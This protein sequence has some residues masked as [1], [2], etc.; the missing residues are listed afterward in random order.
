M[1]NHFII[2]MWNIVLK[3]FYSLLIMVCLLMQACTHN[4]ESEKQNFKKPNLSKAASYNAQLGL[5]YL[6][7]GD[8]PRAK[9]KLLTALEQEPASPDVNSA[10][11]YYFEQTKEL[12][13]AEKYY[14]KAISLTGSG[15]AQLNNYGAFLCRQGDY[16]KAEKYFLKAANDVQYIHTAGAYENAG[17]CAL[18]APNDEKA[19]FYFT[20]ALNQ[21]PSRKVSLYEL[22][23]LEIK[24]GK[25][26][27]AF[28]LVQNHPDLVLND[29]ML[30][31]LAKE[32]SEKV[33]QHQIAAQYEQSINNLNSYIDNS[34]VNNEHNN[35]SG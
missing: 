1:P 29:K 16:K 11:A 4:E 34:G 3:G 28:A 2:L 17:L 13:Q 12:E 25:E 8:R 19:M 9:K 15:G 21:D 33:G 6:K 5:G 10:L 14:L 27:A 26:Q 30:L 23:K 35:H 20:K 18:T 31:S 24:M 7:Q 22:L 32:V